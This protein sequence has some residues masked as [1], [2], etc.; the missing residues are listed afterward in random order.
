MGCA[1]FWAIFS[2]TPLVTLLAFPDSVPFEFWCQ[3][4]P[5]LTYLYRHIFIYRVYKSTV[6]DLSQLLTLPVCIDQQ[7]F[8]FGQTA[9]LLVAVQK[10]HLS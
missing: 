5:L 8:H 4:S 9:D 7:S 10:S 3:N 6:P 1:T 2:Q